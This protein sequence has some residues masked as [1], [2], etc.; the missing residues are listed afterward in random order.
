MCLYHLEKNNNSSLGVRNSK[1][2]RSH[3][4]S[5]CPSHTVKS[6]ECEAAEVRRA[7][8]R[9]DASGQWRA[10]N[11]DSRDIS[12]VVGF[13]CFSQHLHSLKRAYC[14]LVIDHFSNGCSGAIRRLPLKCD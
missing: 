4:Q 2:L 11:T 9:I 6:T 8:L 13:F 3:L 7:G 5:F 1:G 14:L 12:V 10:E